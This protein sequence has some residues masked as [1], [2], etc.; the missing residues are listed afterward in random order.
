MKMISMI[1]MAPLI[2][3]CTVLQAQAPLE[4]IYGSGIHDT[5]SASILAPALPDEEVLYYDGTAVVAQPM[6]D[7]D[8]FP[9]WKTATFPLPA[10]PYLGFRSTAQETRVNPIF[11]DQATPPPANG[12]APLETDPAGDQIFSNPYLDIQSTAVAFSQSKLHF[13]VK[14]NTSTYPVSSGATTFYAYMVVLVDPDA[15]P[16]DDPIVYGLMYTVDLGTI[17]SPGLYKIVGS[18]ISDLVR[19]GDITYSIATDTASLLLSCDLDDLLADVDFAS[20]YD[21]TYPRLTTTAITSRITLTGGNEQADGTEGA[22]LLLLPQILPLQNDANPVLSGAQAEV[23]NTGGG[24]VLLANITY[25]DADAN[26]PRLAQ[27][28]VDDGD[29][30]PLIF[31]PGQTPNYSSAVAFSSAPIPLPD[32]WDLVTFRFRHGDGYVY[33]ELENGVAVSDATAASPALDLSLYPNP[34]ADRLSIEAKGSALPNA[35]LEIF[36]IRGQRMAEQQFSGNSSVIPVEGMPAGLYFLR[37]S[38][39]GHS[40]TRR[41]VIAPF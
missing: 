16:E 2:L 24:D 6:Q 15:L 9:S 40:L 34:V 41:F 4:V 33:Q 1:P 13:S 28:I 17:I 38:A 23:L 26:F 5:N 10:H 21:D 36:N 14:C 20:W 27:V 19:I 25:Y 8:L 7:Y 32:S 29:P 22:K 31:S 30:M 18:G 35:K 3:I 37:I 39:P 11:W 12:Y